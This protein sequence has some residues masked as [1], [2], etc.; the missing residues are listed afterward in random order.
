MKKIRLFEAASQDLTDGFHFYEKQESGLGGYFLD[1]L[2]SDID[3]LLIHAGIHPAF[4]L[5][6]Y[7]MLSKRFP[8]AVYYRIDGNDILV[9]AILD[10][11]KNPAWARSRL[12]NA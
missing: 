5:V 3:S 1:S 2:F 10:C 4:F 9:Y 8:F 6:Y 11:R 7:R 12:R